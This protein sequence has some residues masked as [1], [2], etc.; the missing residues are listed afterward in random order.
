MKA[1]VKPRPVAGESWQKG[2]S[3]TEKPM[4]VV[5]KPDD[6]IIKI[7]AGAICGTDIGIY[8]S[9]DSLH[10]SMQKALVDPII[11]G[12]EFSGHI[13]DAG[14][15]ALKHIAGVVK[16]R[17]AGNPDIRKL[18]KGKS[19]DALA[20]HKVL[21]PLLNEHFSASAEMHIVCHACYQCRLGEYHVCRN[22]V[23]KG[24]HDDGI[25]TEYVKVPAWNLMLYHRKEIP[26]EIIAFMDAIGNATHTVFSAD[27][28]GRSAVVLGCGVQGLMAVAVAKAAGARRIYAT[29]ASH[30]DMTHEKL[31]ANRF[32]L[33]R[34]YGAADCFDTAIPEERERLRS[35]IR[36]DTKGT[37]VDA[38]YEMS[39]SYKAYADAYDVI[40]MGGTFSLLGLPGGTTQSNFA[41]EIIFPGITV[42][43]IIGRR[44]PET[45]N[46]MEKLLKAGLAKKFLK[47]GFIT[48]TL[49][50][51]RFD[52]GFDALAK[53]DAYKVLLKP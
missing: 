5:T 27:V 52:E 34:A 36:Q 20:R 32:A 38:V 7:Y 25:F 23:I 26:L 1:V 39:G 19:G 53:G 51:E 45:W 37:G 35:V 28:K 16:N 10:A 22:T 21:I 40:R 31:E 24:L 13:V 42:K 41:G 50:L 47:S 14:P 3:M 33:A 30:G 44:V 43:G 49:P 6:V 9:K 17:A 2:F 48:H 18:V 15:K 12:H 4:P 29:D 8:H 46:Q 11:V